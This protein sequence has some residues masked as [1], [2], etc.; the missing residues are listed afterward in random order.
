MAKT[1]FETIELAFDSYMDETFV[2]LK[3]NK[4]SP[5]KAEQDALFDKQEDFKNQA[6]ELLCDFID[7]RKSAFDLYAQFKTAYNRQLYQVRLARREF[8]KARSYYEDTRTT[9]H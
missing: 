7:G 1:A 4:H 3:R 5:I 8:H 9:I 2:Y 6:V